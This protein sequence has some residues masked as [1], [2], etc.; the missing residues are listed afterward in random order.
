[1][2]A[3]AGR[4]GGAPP[5]SVE[6]SLSS[7]TADA[8]NGTRCSR[9]ELASRDRPHC[10]GGPNRR[11]SSGY[12]G[13]LG[14]KAFSVRSSRSAHGHSTPSWSC[15]WQP[16]LTVSR[17]KSQFGVDLAVDVDLL[18]SSQKKFEPTYLYCSDFAGGAQCMLEFPVVFECSRG[19]RSK[20]DR[21][22]P[23]KTYS[24]SLSYSS[25]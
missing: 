18:R 3:R 15:L 10:I 22:L 20:A 4:R 12:C 9:R 11:T 5:T 8:L 24:R 21:R 23:A 13:A 7:A 19:S 14:L 1:M 6:S 16:K 2:R 17:F 25:L